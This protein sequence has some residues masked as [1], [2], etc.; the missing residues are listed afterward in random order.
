MEQQVEQ[1]KQNSR[2]NKRSRTIGPTRR[3]EQQ[4]EQEEPNNKSNKR[5]RTIGQAKGA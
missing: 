2:S 1:D 3:V 5:N 4:V